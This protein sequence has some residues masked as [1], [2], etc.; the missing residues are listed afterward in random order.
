MQVNALC[1]CALT[2]NL[3]TYFMTKPFSA[4]DKDIKH[5]LMPEI[6][7]NIVGLNSRDNKKPQTVEEIQALQKQAFEEGRQEGIQ[8]GMADMQAKSKQLVNV[9]N[10][11]ARPLQQLD[12]DMEKELAQFALTI[13]SML[14]KK[15]CSVGAEHIHTLIH[16]TLEY[17]PIN[18]RNVRIKLN[19]ADISLLTQSGVELKAPEWVCVADKVVT[20]GGCVIESDTSQIDATVEAR[21]Q[22]IFDQ[23]TEQR[24]LP[25]G[26]V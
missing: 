4:N 18:S 9:F 5:W 25:S 21:I 1:L 20:Q 17:L 2:F 13:A 8:K 12:A 7:G 3:R 16:E 14:L 10:F 23:I 24:P 22:Q 19:P 11:M 26:D 15:E 6:S